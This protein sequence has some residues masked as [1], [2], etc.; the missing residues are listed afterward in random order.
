M[1]G[2]VYTPS[3]NGRGMANA[4]TGSFFLTETVLIPTTSASGT[5][6]TGTVDLSA[7]VNVPTGQAIS[8]SEVDFIW[9][10][11]SDY[12]GP[13]AQALGADGALNAQLTDLNPGTGFILASDQSLVASQHID[14]DQSNN[15]STSNQDLFP[16]RFGSS[17]T[18]E[19]FTVV[20]DKMY[21]TVG[22][23]GAATTENLYCTARIRAQVIKLS[24]KQWIA[25]AIQSTA[26]DN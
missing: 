26:S 15:V 22:N 19:Q 6:I 12:S 20:N 2:L 3:S 23:D 25:L 4:I 8:I 24:Q 7:Y 1:F 10:V 9:Q 21:L 11:G 16:D 14:V 18:S 5:R 17:A 13:I